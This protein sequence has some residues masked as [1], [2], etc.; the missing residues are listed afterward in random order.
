MIR[1]KPEA[2]SSFAKL[3]FGTASSPSPSASDPHIRTTA[4]MSGGGLCQEEEI[5]FQLVMGS[6]AFLSTFNRFFQ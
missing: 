3:I 6:D 1:A 5:K 2:L 4:A